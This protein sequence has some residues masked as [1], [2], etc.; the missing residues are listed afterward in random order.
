MQESHQAFRIAAEAPVPAMRPNTE[1][2][3]RP[4]P[5]G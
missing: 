3:I 2:D 1:P 4:E 5:P